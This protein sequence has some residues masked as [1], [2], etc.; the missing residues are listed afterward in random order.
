MVVL[1]VFTR[2]CFTATHTLNC[3]SKGISAFKLLRGPVTACH[4]RAILNQVI[5]STILFE[6]DSEV[7]EYVGGCEN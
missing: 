3:F 4:D 7:L 5:I 2:M 1:I 6:G